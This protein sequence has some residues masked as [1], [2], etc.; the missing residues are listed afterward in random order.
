MDKIEKTSCMGLSVA[1]LNM[2]NSTL[3]VSLYVVFCF[4]HIWGVMFSLPNNN[5]LIKIHQKDRKRYPIFGLRALN[6]SFILQAP[7]QDLLKSL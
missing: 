7:P 2:F 4:T 3:C 1:L 5:I 6:N